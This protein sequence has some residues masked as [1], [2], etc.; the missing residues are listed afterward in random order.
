MFFPD[1]H[2]LTGV[3]AGEVQR[4]VLY[5][6]RYL[7]VR[8]YTVA[9]CSSV[10]GLESTRFTRPFCVGLHIHSLRVA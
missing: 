3:F 4:R 5:V 9:V 7:T 2:E 6:T 10:G 8:S 1:V